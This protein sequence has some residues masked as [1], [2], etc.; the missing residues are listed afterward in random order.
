MYVIKRSGEREELN[1][2]KVIAS[3]MRTGMPESEARKVM[4]LIRPQLYD[5]IT[6]EEIYRRVNKVLD[7][8]RKVRFGLKKAILNLGPEGYYFEDFIARLF[9]AMG[10]DILVRQS[11]QGQCICHEVDIV[12]KNG[13]GKAMVECKFHNSQGIKCSAQTALYT[14]GR[15]LDLSHVH[16]LDHVWLVTNTRFSSD[17]IRYAEC[18]N[19]KLLGWRYPEG[20]GLEGLVER[21]R[22]YPITALDLRRADIK[23]LLEND[24]ILIKDMIERE[25]L[26][27]RLLPGRDMDRIM[28]EI[29]AL[30]K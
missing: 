8:E 10:H 5:G 1:A 20:E 15:F 17:V 18:M 6:T 28:H 12:L 19:M 25:E 26:V 3:I 23:A 27:H 24:I 7:S 14:Y 30:M 22:L 21:Y 29:H 4:D 13:S 11:L 16:Q 2:E 9:K